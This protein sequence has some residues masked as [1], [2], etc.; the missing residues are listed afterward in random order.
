MA[1]ESLLVHP[2]YIGLSPSSP[3]SKENGNHP[4]ERPSTV[5]RKS[6]SSL[7]KNL[8]PGKYP[9]LFYQTKNVFS[10]GVAKINEVFSDLKCSIQSSTQVHLC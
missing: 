8:F 9:T 2:D 6:K 3:D 5:G 10:I 4:M 7:R 1:S